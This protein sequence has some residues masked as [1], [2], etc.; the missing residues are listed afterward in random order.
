MRRPISSSPVCAEP[1]PTASVPAT[2]SG[3]GLAPLEPVQ[4]HTFRAFPAALL[5]TLLACDAPPEQPDAPADESVDE[6]GDEFV[7]ESVVAQTTVLW[8]RFKQTSAFVTG[9]DVVVPENMRLVF[10]GRFLDSQAAE[11]SW[12]GDSQ[13]TLAGRGELDPLV[14]NGLRSLTHPQ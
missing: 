4:L 1:Q 5:L 9:A 13:V 14:S 8:S 3:T 11:R 6:S 12:P 7:D 2:S 10:D